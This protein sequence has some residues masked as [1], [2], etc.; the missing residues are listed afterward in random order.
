MIKFPTREDLVGMMF[1]HKSSGN[2]DSLRRVRGQR[3]GVP[4]AEE[5]RQARLES[6]QKGGRGDLRYPRPWSM[7]VVWTEL[8]KTAGSLE[9]ELG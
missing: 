5:G 6:F 2:L 7:E 4:M 8:R 1:L 3:V 9:A